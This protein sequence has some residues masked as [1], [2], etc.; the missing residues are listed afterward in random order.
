VQPDESGARATSSFL[1]C[2]GGVG[3]GTWT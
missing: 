2:P 1:M 3:Q